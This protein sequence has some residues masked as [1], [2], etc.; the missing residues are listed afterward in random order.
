MKSL[1]DEELI[2][3]IEEY[4]LSDNEYA[5]LID[6]EWG[7]GKTYF[8]ENKLVK[9]FNNLKESGATNK[10]C[11]YVSLYG[12][13]SK[14]EIENK[15]TEKILEQSSKNYGK[16]LARSFKNTKSLSNIINVVIP[17]D[18]TN[19]IGK[20]DIASIINKFQCVESQIL[21]FDDLE[22]VEMDYNEVFGFINEYIEHKKNKCIIFV[23]QCEIQKNNI[24]KNIELK[25]LTA[26]VMKEFNTSEK[27][28]ENGK[29]LDKEILSRDVVEL[30]SD[31]LSYKKIKEKV[32]GKEIKYI[33]NITEVCKKLADEI[34]KEEKT[35]EIL[36][37]C[38]STI[39]KRMQREK[40]CNIRT[41][42][43][44]IEKFKTIVIELESSEIK[45]IEFYDVILNDVLLAL[46]SSFIEKKKNDRVRIWGAKEHYIPGDYP[47]FR[48]IDN[49]IMTEKLDVKYMIE[50][51]NDYDNILKN[52]IENS[53]NKEIKYLR[54]NYYIM[55]DNELETILKTIKG[56]LEKDDYKIISY[57]Q[58][59]EILLVIEMYEL[60]ETK[61]EE[62]FELMKQNI[63]CNPGYYCFDDDVYLLADNSLHKFRDCMNELRE[64]L[65]KEQKQKRMFG[66]N[67]IINGENCWGKKLNEY[68]EQYS[69][70][71]SNFFIKE[72]DVEHLIEILKESET[73]DIFEVRRIF[74]NSKI[75]EEDIEK[76][77]NLINLLDEL[78][79]KEVR[80]TQ[81]VNL[82]WL[83]EDLNARVK[84]LKCDKQ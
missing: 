66:M 24:M 56:K 51:L 71:E 33:P 39:E 65:E 45:N 40:H 6:G 2:N 60:S 8:A 1:N 12:V 61:F 69:G 81:K 83:R 70:Y 50:S 80:R 36:I 57:P 28:K 34:I 17:E 38:A 46:L 48:F 82:K 4:I 11:I 52:E 10:E 31:D 43:L 23:N 19:Q 64:L 74:Y 75:K 67:A 72:I 14:Q 42:K 13:N 26:E 25:Y 63:K 73:Q 21:I 59:L 68:L 77:N 30:Y 76:I 3:V 49:F 9:H 16:F 20:I 18:V 62:Y 58:I 47:E 7:S 44:I 22:R 27:Q 55:E 41:L 32:I 54:N 84:E 35:K 37:N 53:N 78:I 29:I 79:K 5:I 15:M